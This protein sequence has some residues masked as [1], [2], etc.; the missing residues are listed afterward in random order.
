MSIDTDL[1]LRRL[2]LPEGEGPTMLWL[3]GLTDSGSGWPSAEEHWSAS[4]SILAVDQRGHGSSPRFTPE[5][6]EAHPGDVMVDD[7]LAILQQLDTPPVVIGHS[8]GGAVALN[9]GVRRPDLVAALVLEDPAPLSPGEKQHDPARGDNLLAGLRSSLEASDE[10][11]LFRRRKA[12]H[13]D[14][15]E[16]ELLVTGQAERQIDLEYA[17]HGDHKPSTPW[18]RLFTE[19]SVPTLVLTGDSM[20]EV[21]ITRDIEDG[22][23]QIGNPHVQVVR[24]PAAGHCIRREQPEAFFSTVDEFLGGIPGR[25]G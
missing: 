19:V 20:E 8:L 2:G 1:H 4:Y 23:A 17:R 9:A 15:P 22:I 18:P 21:C 3:H 11:D 7:A 5:Q 24:I 16:G 10:E 25:L 12:A 6:L 14:W 13:P